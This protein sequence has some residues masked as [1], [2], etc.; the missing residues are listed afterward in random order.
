MVLFEMTIILA[1]TSCSVLLSAY[2]E[3]ENPCL[4]FEVMLLFPPL[5]P[6]HNVYGMIYSVKVDEAKSSHRA[7][8]L[9]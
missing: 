5:A 1:I 6:L 9:F 3:L 7:Q 2:L 8:M 4:P